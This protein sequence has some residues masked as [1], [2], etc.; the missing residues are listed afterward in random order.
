MGRGRANSGVSGGGVSMK[1][2]STRYSQPLKHLCHSHSGYAQ[3]LRQSP[4]AK[5]ATCLLPAKI[6]L[7]RSCKDASKVRSR[8]RCAFSLYGL[9]KNG[10][11]GV[12]A[13]ADQPIMANRQCQSHPPEA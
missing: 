8:H 1:H 10:L 4:P 13:V 6:T 9:M 11:S 2:D 3:H 7:V 12:M 5:S